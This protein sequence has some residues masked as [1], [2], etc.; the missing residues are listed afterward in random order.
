MELGK[1]GGRV[2]FDIYTFFQRLGNGGGGQV[3]T[4]YV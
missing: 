1:R 4:N 3:F 2:E